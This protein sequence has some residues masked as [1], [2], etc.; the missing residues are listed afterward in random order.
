MES[1]TAMHLRHIDES[2]AD[3]YE[4]EDDGRENISSGDECCLQNFY[5]DFEKP[6][7]LKYITNNDDY[8]PQFKTTGVS[9][10]EEKKEES[11]DDSLLQAEENLNYKHSDHMFE[12]ISNDC[13]LA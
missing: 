4:E 2:V 1:F 9:N 7:M 13:L 3:Q 12:D 5:S 11:F 6:R 10:G 8:S